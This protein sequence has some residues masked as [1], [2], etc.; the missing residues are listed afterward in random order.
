M[1]NFEKQIQKAAEGYSLS[2][3]ERERM[4][5]IL[6]DYM[7]FKPVRGGKAG[8]P[9]SAFAWLSYL[10]RPIAAALVMV[11]VTSSTAAYAAESALPGDALYAVKTYVTEPARVALATNAEAK[12]EVQMEIAERRIEEATTLSAE[13]RLDDSTQDSLAAS[14]KSYAAAVSENIEKTA[15]EDTSA[16][17]ELAERFETRLVAHESVLAEVEI[18]QEDEDNHSRR[19]SDAIRETSETLAVA[20]FNR[21]AEVAT[22]TIAAETEVTLVTTGVIE[23]AAISTAT[24]P[25]AMTM[26]VATEPPA[27][28]ESARSMKVTASVPAPTPEPDSRTISRMKS[29]AERSLSN[30]EKALRKS[31]SISAEAKARAEADIALAQASFEA[32]EEL[33]GNDENREAL[34][35]FKES[36]R[37][38]EQAIVYIKAAP[39]LEKA[40]ARNS[41]R[42]RGSDSS[43]TK[44]D[45]TI[46]VTIPG[47]SVTTTITASTSVESNETT[48]HDEPDNGREEDSSDERSEESEKPSSSIKLFQKFNISL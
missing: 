41:S 35:S 40:R 5:R 33:M 46:N 12:A 11:L 10:H 48:S 28:A 44:T 22:D 15:S 20:H 38:S 32:G 34:A 30:A 16:S 23:D 43:T 2:T 25:V 26:S 24:E 13:G 9:Q 31:R 19:L 21:S 37:V 4:E 1:T 39:S 42:N 7:K 8:A 36:I 29:S 6:K 47:A 27:Q 45:T 14:F 3:D 18:D 17:L